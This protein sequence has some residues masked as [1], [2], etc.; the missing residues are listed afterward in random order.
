VG[1]LPQLPL[2]CL[3]AFGCYSLSVI[4]MNLVRFR[5]CPEAARELDAVSCVCCQS[6]L[7]AFQQ[8]LDEVRKE[9]AEKGYTAR[10]K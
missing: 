5:D 6:A 3:V 8:E 4:G 2:W 7:I 9:L 1:D 10:R